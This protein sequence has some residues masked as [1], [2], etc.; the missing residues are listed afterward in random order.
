[1]K[2]YI[3]SDAIRIEKNIIIF[4]KEICK[5]EKFNSKNMFL[6]LENNILFAGFSSDENLHLEISDKHWQPV[7][8]C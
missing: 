2:K 5:H 3:S 4:L 7:Y 6:Y 8:E 1:M